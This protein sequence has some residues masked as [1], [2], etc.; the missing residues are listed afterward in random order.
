MGSLRTC[1]SILNRRMF[2]IVRHFRNLGVSIVQL[3]DAKSIRK[4]IPFDLSSAN[5]F[6]RAGALD[7]AVWPFR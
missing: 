1:A 5:D 4:L 2:R 6:Q 3:G 7:I